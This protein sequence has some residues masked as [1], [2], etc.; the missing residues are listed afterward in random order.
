[1][2]RWALA[3]VLVLVA[4]ACAGEEG[5][6]R[7]HRHRRHRHRRHHPA[8][9]HDAPGGEGSRILRRVCAP[10]A[11]CERFAGCALAEEQPDPEVPGQIRYLVQRYDPEPA[12][13]GTVIEWGRLCWS[14][15]SGRSCVDAFESG[16]RCAQD[17]SQGL[18]TEA[19][20]RCEAIAGVCAASVADAGPASQSP[21]APDG[22]VAAPAP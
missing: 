6:R 8:V 9:V 15:P 16:I 18:A 17:E 21:A 10:V 14:E 3:M 1:M 19:P 22:G 20:P 5:H 7:R 11:K 4:A 2:A 13:V 12:R